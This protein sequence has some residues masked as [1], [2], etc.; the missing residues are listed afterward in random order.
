MK[1]IFRLL[2]IL[3]LILH[4]PNLIASSDSDELKAIS[5]QVAALRQEVA[6]LKNSVE[7]LMKLRPSVTMM[8]P[9]ISERLHVM[10]YAGDAEDWAVASHELNVLKGL[11]S[12]LELVDPERGAMAKGFLLGPFSQIEAAIEHGN[13]ESF[14]EA[15]DAT[16]ANCN[17]CHVAAGSP[18]MRVVLDA[19]DSLSMRH[20]H[21]LGKSEKPGDHMH[22]H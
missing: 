16:V 6:D 10:H 20:S 13:Q 21:A 22:T 9:E 3:V 12:R 11:V 18:T 15:L 7:M 4:S 2:P 14:D 8:M 5:G 17:S 1:V 19:T